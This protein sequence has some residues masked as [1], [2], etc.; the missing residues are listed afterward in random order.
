MKRAL[1]L[2][3]GG[4]RGAYEMGAWQAL[5]ELGI[6]FSAVY[7]ASIGA[8]N[9][10]LVAQGDLDEALKLWSNITVLQVVSVENEEDFSIER[11][12]SRKRDVIPFLLENARHL[13]VDI[14]PLE[15]MVNEKIDERRIRARG[16]SLGVMTYKMPQMQAAPMTLNNMAPG[17]LGDWI[18]A[19][20]SCF[21]IF[22]AKH[23][24]NQRYID[25]GYYDNLPIDM[26][27]ADGADEVVAVELH[28][29]HTHPEYARMPWLRTIKPLHNLGGF[30][31]FNP[32]LLRRSRLMGYYD[33]MK[34]YRHFD[35]FLY[36]FQRVNALEVTPAAR[37]FM[38]SITAFDA[39]ILRRGALYAGQSVNAPLVTAIEAETE[40]RMLN[41]KDI[42]LRGLE[43]CA[44][45]MVFRTDAVY[46]ADVLLQQM[47]TFVRAGEPVQDMDESSIRAAVRD[48]SRVLTAYLYRG[49]R[50]TGSFPQDCLRLLAE[51][52]VATAAAMFLACL[53]AD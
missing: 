17:T 37:R 41:W 8:L 53:G 12:V 43:L 27:L 36:T 24:D 25:G 45:S 26:A 20:A 16:M 33:T 28:A 19:S 31:D 38:R 52:P 7:G 11:M 15:N 42:W 30:L 47:L 40:Q 39:E 1:V 13:R 22:P 6:R 18:I 35:G 48:G 4:S 32:K 3:G 5:E 44:Q 46:T 29:E 51:H 10:A 2:S 14:S 21:P 9:A 50:T 23:I 49:L 34:C